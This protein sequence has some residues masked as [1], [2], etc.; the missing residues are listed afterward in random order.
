MQ[1]RV[2]KI[3]V[4]CLY[5]WASSAFPIIVTTFIFAT[6]F[7]TKIAP[8]EITGTYLWANAVALAGIIIAFLS[9]LFGAIAD[10]SGFHKRWLFFFTWLC[11]I[12]TSLLW[13]AYPKASAIPLTLTCLVIGTIGLEMALVFYNAFLPQLAP[14][15]YLGRISGWGWGAGYMGGIVA[16]MITLFVFVQTKIAWI[17]TQQA[18][19]IRLSGPFVALWYAVFSLPF[20]IFIPEMS[21]S[22]QRI[23]KAIFAGWKDLLATLKRLPREK[24]ILRYL[25]A[26]MVYTDGLNTL[27]AFGGIYAAGTYHLDFTQILIFGI[28]MN[29]AAGTGAIGL[30]WLDDYLG[31]KPTILLSLICLMLAGVPILFLHDKYLFWGFAML[32]CLFVG[33]TQAASRSL[34]ARLIPEKNMQAEMFGLY[35]LSGKV[36]AFI[37]PWLLGWATLAFQ[38]Q[39]VGVATIFIFF[40]V[41]ALL[42]LGVKSRVD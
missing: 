20:F 36:T 12:S 19:H 22:R 1:S 26:H 25:I 33:P 15:H 38:S 21:S 17:D 14:P 35:A 29:I 27:F 10:R 42:L 4:W 7:T 28:T 9:P 30:A 24:N 18:E 31:S 16:L 32:L 37:G 23:K 3:G 2:F 13:F 11:I 6:Y 39:R 34:M 40:L 41:G 8:N 5:E